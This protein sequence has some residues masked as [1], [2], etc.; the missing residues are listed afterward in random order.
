MVKT[1]GL[2]VPK[3]QGNGTKSS[4]KGLNRVARGSGIKSRYL[5]S[6]GGRKKRLV[7]T[8]QPREEKREP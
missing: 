3:E 5:G 6:E 1:K 4:I 2:C 8:D 7:Q